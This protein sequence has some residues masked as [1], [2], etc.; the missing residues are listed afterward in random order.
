MAAGAGPGH[1]SGDVPAGRQ[2]R[3]GDPGRVRADPAVHGPPL[4]RRRRGLLLP[5]PDRPPRRGTAGNRAEP[6]TGSR[7][8][9]GNGSASATANARS[10]AATTRPWTT[11]PTTS[12]PGPTEVPPASPTSA[13]PAPNTTASN[14]AP[15]GH[16]PG[17]ARTIRRDGFHR[18]AGPIPAS[19]RTGNHPTGRTAS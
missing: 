16:P 18:P 19:T 17:P 5:G 3:T 7:R 13:N 1:R 2:R 12:W 11:K 14:T 6:A 4:D 8:P 15:A 10:R 9:S